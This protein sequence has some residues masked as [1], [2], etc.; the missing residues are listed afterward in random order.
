MHIWG[1]TDFDWES[2]DQACMY[3][4]RRCRQF[5]RL[6][7]H[8]KEKF[9]TLRVEDTVAFY[10]EW[11]LH[12][13]IRPGYYRYTFPKEMLLYVEPI[14]RTISSKIGITYLIN[15]YQ[16]W[17]LKYFWKRAAKKWPHIK[18]EILNDYHWIV[19]D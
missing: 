2:L 3:L 17:V 11:P 15:K 5:A 19:G 12:N 10:G 6:G 13:L 18:E 16:M 4:S 9:G 8:T 7:I 1:D 14:L